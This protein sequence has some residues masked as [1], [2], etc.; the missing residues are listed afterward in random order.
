M[1]LQNSFCFFVDILI[2]EFLAV[3]GANSTVNGEL[4]NHF[5][6]FFA[7]GKADVE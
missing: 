7:F 5:K 4:Q 6:S 1:R 2:F 3:T